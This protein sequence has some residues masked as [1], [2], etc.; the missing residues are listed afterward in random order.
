MKDNRILLMG[1]PGAGKSNVSETLGTVFTYMLVMEWIEYQ[2]LHTAQ[3]QLLHRHYHRIVEPKGERVEAHFAAAHPGDIPPSI[4]RT[5]DKAIAGKRFVFR[6]ISTGEV[7][8]DR[9]RQGMLPDD[10]KARVERGDLVSDAYVQR[11]LEE[12]LVEAR[13]RNS[14]LDG[15]PRNPDQ[16]ENIWNTL[17]KYDE[18]RRDSGERPLDY[19]VHVTIEREEAERRLVGRRVCPNQSCE[20]ASLSY[21][22]FF[23]NFK[24][25]KS[26]IKSS[27]GDYETG[28]CDACETELVR[29]D[30]DSPEVFNR[31]WEQYVAEILPVLNELRE[32]CRMRIHDIPAKMPTEVISSHIIY[33]MGALKSRYVLGK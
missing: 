5:L 1:P 20:R 33:Q 30:D 21:N 13:W 16:L 6:R 18:N 2:T 31:R 19:V 12:L 8:R 17:E 22:I 10:E 14:L 26:G 7:L 28:I 3:E 32:K 24:P 9:I 27:D 25:R 15:Y 23:E 29:R 11:V 4:L